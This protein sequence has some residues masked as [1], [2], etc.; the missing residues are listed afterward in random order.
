[1]NVNDALPY[2]LTQSIFDENNF[3]AL[4]AGDSERNAESG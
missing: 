3:G 2:A 1:M 4:S